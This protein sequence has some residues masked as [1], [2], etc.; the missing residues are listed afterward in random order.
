M[1]WTEEQKL[2]FELAVEVLS[3]EVGRRTAALRVLSDD[4]PELRVRLQSER[5]RIIHLSN[6]PSVDDDCRISSILDRDIEE[7][8]REEPVL[9]RAG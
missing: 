5:T 7:A 2:R 3:G 9:R 1:T 4:Q 6:R 8:L